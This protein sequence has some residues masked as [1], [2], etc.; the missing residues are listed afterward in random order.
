M[1]TLDGAG[2]DAFPEVTP[3]IPDPTMTGTNLDVELA[4]PAQPS[5]VPSEVEPQ[6]EAGA[7]SASLQGNSPFDGALTGSLGNIGV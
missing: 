1:N 2:G 6:A 3:A 5:S 4:T 7:L